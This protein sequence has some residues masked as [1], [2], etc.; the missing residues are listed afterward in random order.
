MPPTRGQ[1]EVI[2]IPDSPTAP[3]E[4]IVIS[5]DEV[6]ELLDYRAKQV[7]LPRIPSIQPACKP[8]GE[9]NP[10]PMIPAL[11]DIKSSSDVPIA[12]Q[13]LVMSFQSLSSGHGHPTREDFLLEVL[14]RELREISQEVE[15]DS[16]S[17]L[18]QIIQDAKSRPEPSYRD[19][20]KTVSFFQGLK[21]RRTSAPSRGIVHHA[22]K[23]TRVPN[24]SQGESIHTLTRAV[25]KFNSYIEIERS[26]LANRTRLPPQSDKNN[27]SKED[28]DATIKSMQVYAKSAKQSRRREKLARIGAYLPRI[29]SAHQDCKDNLDEEGLYESLDHRDPKNPSYHV[30]KAFEMPLRSFLGPETLVAKPQNSISALLDPLAQTLERYARASCLI[31]SAHECQIHGKF[32][33]DSV[34]DDSDTNNTTDEEGPSNGSGT[35]YHLYN[36]P[37]TR[38][39]ASYGGVNSI[40]SEFADDLYCG[41]Q[42]EQ[43]DCSA[44]CRLNPSNAELNSEGTWTSEDHASMQVLAFYMQIRKD[45]IASCFIAPMLGKP[46]SEV[47]H[48]LKKLGTQRVGLGDMVA[49]ID[50]RSKKPN[51]VD[52]E[53]EYKHD[54]RLQPKPCYHPGQNCF[55]A[56]KKC[57]C[58]MHDTP[59]ATVPG[60]VFSRRHAPVAVST[61]NVTQ[62]SA[63]GAGLP[64]QLGLKVQSPARIATTVRSSVPRGKKYW[65]ER[66]LSMALGMGCTWRNEPV[67]VGDFIAEYVGEII[68]E[69]ELDRR[70]AIKRRMGMSYNFTLNAETT[71]DAMW[72]GNATRFI[73]HS[74]IRKN[75]RA[76]VL[77]VNCEHRIAF[78]A[79]ENLDAGE[80]LFF[81]YGKD[82][83]TIE[84]LKEDDISPSARKKSASKQKRAE[85]LESAVA[86]TEAGVEPEANDEEGQG[87]AFEDEAFL[88]YLAK[89]RKKPASDDDDDYV[90]RGSQ[91]GPQRARPAL[92]SKRSRR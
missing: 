61:E 40:E 13:G 73:N 14:D 7:N 56:G 9:D 68:T 33:D 57:T 72:Y 63:V 64:T 78:F 27:V 86:N 32:D 90:E 84:E 23:R 43:N 21:E 37:H 17:T 71:I 26:I 88:D 20:A 70:E 55:A 81:D 4:A 5:D 69:P 67:Q 46:C 45:R 18:A 77:L 47:H 79:T 22:A 85:P 66:A 59:D 83:K 28:K 52:L 89:T 29:R 51:W 75:C 50:K 44:E 82:F 65:W 34:E 54:K 41:E 8:E 25:P 53:G 49:G 92:R 36:M 35:T 48:R 39:R 58:A 38:M 10:E 87:D 62:I 19:M 31:C 11:V 15:K 30:E 2:E 3:P 60:R 6:T 1:P 42:S 80:E 16:S 74:T 24:S 76:K 91:S 12:S